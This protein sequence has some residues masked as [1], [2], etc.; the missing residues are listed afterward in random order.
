MWVAA[1]FQ[2]ERAANYWLDALSS[3]AQQLARCWEMEAND[4]MDLIKG[5]AKEYYQAC[6]E[7]CSRVESIK[8]ASPTPRGRDSCVVNSIFLKFELL[9]IFEDLVAFS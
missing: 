4:G 5:G 3:K 2:T 1:T 8:T 7:E 6:S 9:Y